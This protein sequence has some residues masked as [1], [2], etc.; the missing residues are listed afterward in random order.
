MLK[1]NDE[2]ALKDVREAVLQA[3]RI[4]IAMLRQFCP[5]GRHM[6]P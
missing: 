1:L 6:F 5:Y 3:H 2:A 4:A